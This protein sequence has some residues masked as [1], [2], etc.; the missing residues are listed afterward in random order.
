MT[1]WLRR[2]RALRHRRWQSVLAAAAI[3]AAV[4]LPVVL[5]SVGGGVANHEI[6]A[7]QNSGYQV[8]VS[9]PGLHGVEHAHALAGSIDA[10]PRVAIASPILSVPIDAFPSGQAPTPVLAEGVI[11][12]AFE[13]TLSAEEGPFFPHPLPFSEPTDL[14][15]YA[16]GTYAGAPSLEVM[17]AGPLAQAE[18]LGVGDTLPLGPTSDANGSAPFRIVGTFGVPKTAIGPT[19]A[20]AIVLPLSDLQQLVGLGVGASG[21]SPI[22]AADTIDVALAGAAA[23]DPSAVHEVGDAIAALVPFYSVA[24]L[25]DQAAQLGES[26]AVLTG[27]YLALSSVGLSVGIVFL[28]LVL[29]RQVET[30]RRVI[31]IRR[32]LGVPARQVAV[33]WLGASL[34]LTGVGVLAGLVGGWAIIAYLARYGVGA[35]ATAAQLAEFDPLTLALLALAVL[36]LGSLASLAATRRALRLP[37]WEVLR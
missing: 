27:F 31:G 4:A 19:A 16:N 14:V 1:T 6:H 30:D 25:T 29:I 33:G 12:N 20:F 37:I 5:L 28:A 36:L 11:P 32:A 17:I 24:A 21:G 13:A 26:A 2:W 9:A 10:L 35:V 7:L 23:T 8:T 3:A 34:R 18:G 15:H 22:D